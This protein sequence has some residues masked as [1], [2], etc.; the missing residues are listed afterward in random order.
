MMIAD[1]GGYTRYMRLHRMSL[2]HSQEITS[3]LLEA[4]VR[5]APPLKLIEVE[6]DA[7]FLSTSIRGDAMSTVGIVADVAV[8]MH[9]AFHA[10]QDRMVALNMCSCPGCIEAGRL[11][12]KFVAH[13]GEVARQTIRKREQ[14]VG[15]DV[16]VV[17]RMLK[18]SVPI[19][20]YVLMSEPVYRE[21]APLVRERV[22]D[23]EDEL[24]GLGLTTL[25]FVDLQSLAPAR[26]SVPTPT[27]ARRVRKTLGVVVRATPR[28][29]RKQRQRAVADGF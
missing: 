24:E 18:N 19:E 23:L 2:A 29:L 20:E 28:M 26:A 9:A 11:R 27:L 12:V 13:V 7:A 15:L 25:Y 10:E 8:S 21:S 5:A 1:I 4:L 22:T 16:I 6:G 14:L 3:R 17:H